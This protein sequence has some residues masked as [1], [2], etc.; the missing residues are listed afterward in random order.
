[1]THSA[2]FATVH[3]IGPNT[4]LA[5]T[6]TAHTF[7]STP[8]HS[9][10]SPHKSLPLICHAQTRFPQQMHL[11]P[12]TSPYQSEETPIL[13]T[14]S[15]LYSSRF[16]TST[17]SATLPA[18][19]GC[20]IYLLKH[21]SPTASLGLCPISPPSGQT[22]T[23]DQS[24]PPPTGTANST[25]ASMDPRRL[26]KCYALSTPTHGDIPRPISSSAAACRDATRACTYRRL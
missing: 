17:N 5:D 13:S 25:K 22:S 23:S 15:H 9:P 8:S 11:C 19:P 3:S 4:V 18:L 10:L 2:D 16:F 24:A 14:P 21:S 12:C 6:L 20:N 7:L 26:N 1:M